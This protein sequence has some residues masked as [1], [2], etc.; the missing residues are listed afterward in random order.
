MNNTISE[1]VIICPTMLGCRWYGN[2][3]QAF[4]GLKEGGVFLIGMTNDIINNRAIGME[5]GFWSPGNSV[6]WGKGRV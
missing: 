3:W 4:N 6:Y 2:D 1:N 5:H